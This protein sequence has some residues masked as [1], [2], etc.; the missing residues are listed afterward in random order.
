MP[1]QSLVDPD[2]LFDPLNPVPV[3]GNPTLNAVMRG[4]TLRPVYMSTEP[5]AYVRI[6]NLEITNISG[7]GYSGASA[8]FMRDTAH[9]VHAMDTKPGDSLLWIEA[10]AR[11]KLKHHEMAGIHVKPNRELEIKGCKIVYSGYSKDAEEQ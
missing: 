6:E 7:A 3:P 2:V 10:E 4:F 5:V 8:I 9:I 11:R 1:D